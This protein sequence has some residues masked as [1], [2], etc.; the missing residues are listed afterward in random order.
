MCPWT[1]QCHHAASAPTS[2]QR[3]DWILSPATLTLPLPLGFWRHREV[4]GGLA[5][6]LDGRLPRACPQ[7][8]PQA[9][10]G[11]GGSPGLLDDLRPHPATVSEACRYFPPPQLSADVKGA[12]GLGLGPWASRRV[13][14]A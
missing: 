3:E 4:T 1:T 8:F 5:Q 9:K 12:L 13:P 7:P 11:R 6:P 2:I 14:I 10:K